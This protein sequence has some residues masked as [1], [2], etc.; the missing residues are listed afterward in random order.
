M[1]KLLINKLKTDL[2][3]EKTPSSNQG[4]T[5]KK[6]FNIL[7]EQLGPNL[8]AMSNF[9]GNISG[10]DKFDLDSLNPFKSSKEQFTGFEGHGD[11]NKHSI[12]TTIDGKI[13]IDPT[14]DI[15]QE[16]YNLFKKLQFFKIHNNSQGSW[17]LLWFLVLAVLI[18]IKLYMFIS[19]FVFGKTPKLPKASDMPKSS[20]MPKASD[21]PKK[22]KT[23]DM[24]NAS[25]TPKNKNS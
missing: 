6:K 14:T 17:L 25:D 1:T 23:P 20:D 15:N 21:M 18:F 22:I 24:P 11:E 2:D 10:V 13:N 19:T 9:F 3:S 4:A 5:I 12:Y 7:E 16:E 8:E